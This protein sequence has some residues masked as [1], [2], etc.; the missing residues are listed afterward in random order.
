MAESTKGNITVR[1]VYRSH[2]H[3][4]IWE[5]IEKAH[6]WEQVGIEPTQ[7]EYC[8]SPPVAEAALFDGS[9]D[10]ISGNHLTPYVLVAEGKP[11][12]SIASP[13]NAT[14]ATI[15]STQP[16]K[17]VLDLRG[18]RV[19]DTPLEGRDGGFHHGRGNHM[20]YIVRAGMRLDEIKWV[21]VE[22]RAQQ[23]EDAGGKSR[24][25]LCLG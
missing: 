10:F 16:I 24:C 17:S 20:M 25:S 21:D 1:G 23:L 12:V 14:R 8:E 6:I 3:L 4:P 22:G 19:A 11:I 9:I 7:M 18:K 13:V 15:T 2:S 5:V